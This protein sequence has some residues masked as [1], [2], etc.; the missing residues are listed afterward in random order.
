[1]EKPYSGNEAGPSPSRRIRGTATWPH[2]HAVIQTQ[3]R[4]T[5]AAATH[6]TPD[7]RKVIAESQS[8]SSLHMSPFARM[9]G[10]RKNLRI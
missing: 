9:S 7:N 5:N 2:G 8:I 4:S 1:M 10:T 3:H 6:P